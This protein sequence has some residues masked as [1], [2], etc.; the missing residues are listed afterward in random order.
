V[1]EQNLKIGCIKGLGL[2]CLMPHATILSD[3]YRGRMVFNTN[4]NNV[5]ATPLRSVLW[6][7]ESVESGETHRPVT[8]H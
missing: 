1:S 2:W 7:E 5:P 3:M 8:S 6:I 4:F